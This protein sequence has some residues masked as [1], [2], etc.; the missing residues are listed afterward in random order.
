MCVRSVLAV[1]GLLLVAMPASAHK[2][3][4]SY[5]WIDLSAA[6]PALR[7]DI[8]LTDL[9]DAVGLDLD[10]DGD[11]SWGELKARHTLVASYARAHLAVSDTA[12]RCSWNA[13]SQRVAEHSDGAYSV[14][15][16]ALGCPA[17]APLR[18]DYHLRFD[19]DPTHRAVVRVR[20]AAGEQLAVLSDANRSLQ[21][22]APA[23]L[24]GVS[25]LRQGIVH[26]LAGYDHL[27][28]L[29]V[30]LLPCLRMRAQLAPIATIVTTF[31]LAHSLTLGLAAF[32]L[33][34]LP[35]RLVESAI[36]AS[37]VLVALLNLRPRGVASLR[38]RCAVV[39]ALGL[40]HGLGFAGVLDGLGA[41]GSVTVL[42]LAWFNLG[43]EVGQLGVVLCAW[44]LLAYLARQPVVGALVL[45]AGSALAAAIGTVWFAQRCFEVSTGS[46]TLLVAGAL[47]LLLVAISHFGSAL[48]SRTQLTTTERFAPAP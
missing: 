1:V 20:S 47:G 29:F 37:I 13:L 24:N 36:A 30:L 8:S 35:A 15:S 38:S 34:S 40:L 7:W 18:L 31:T 44:P 42:A 43:I 14:L 45:R 6:T 19:A 2:A 25:F 10:R 48:S 17:G 22:D 9:E 21:L 16:F 28:F 3:S 39:F 32:E 33:V 5:L 41:A 4:D 23:P 46:V 12:G 11:I 26:M 27:L